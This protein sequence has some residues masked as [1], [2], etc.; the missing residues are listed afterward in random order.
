MT[1]DPT[2]LDRLDAAEKEATKAPW[3]NRWIQNGTAADAELVALSRNHLRALIDVARAAEGWQN[4]EIEATHW[5]MHDPACPCCISQ[6]QLLE[7]LVPL[8]SPTDE[9]DTRPTGNMGGLL[10]QEQAD[11]LRRAR[12][13]D[14]RPEHLG[15]A[16]AS[17]EKR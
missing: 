2:P 12:E 15:S 6:R 3:P 1:P 17:G 16:D 9:K 14:T 4:S 10:H 13:K 11:H 5:L 7:A 8:L